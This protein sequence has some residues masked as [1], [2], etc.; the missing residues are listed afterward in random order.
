MND[1]D[2][3]ALALEEARIAGDSGDVPIGAI[4]VHDG[5]VIAKGHNQREQTNDPVAHAEILAL[6]Q[7]AK[8]M[9]SWQLVDC[10][11][12]ATLE[13]CAMCAGALVNSRIKRLVYGAAD[14]RAGATNS[15]YEICSDK[16]LNHTV[17]ITT[18]VG[19]EESAQLL[20]DFFAD[21]RS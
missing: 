20:R 4:I 3:I 19:A 7:A 13:P 9:G 16:R 12:Y 2:A 14:P 8:V 11:L 18:G 10:T 1:L 5:T 21:K 15:L 6:Q 17:E